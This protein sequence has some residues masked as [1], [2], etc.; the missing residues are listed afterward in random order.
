MCFIGHRAT[1]RK[2][3]EKRIKFNKQKI[4]SPINNNLKIKQNGTRNDHSQPQKPSDIKYFKFKPKNS[5]LTKG[6]YHKIE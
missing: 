2:N 5:K 3:N 6:E 1:T 4:F